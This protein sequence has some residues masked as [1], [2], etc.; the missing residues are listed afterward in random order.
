MSEAMSEPSLTPEMEQE[1][2]KYLAAEGGEAMYESDEWLAAQRAEI[3]ALRAERD[4]AN[5]AAAGLARVLV[6]REAQ[7]DAAITHALRVRLGTLLAP[8]PGAVSAEDLPE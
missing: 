1:I 5:N 8:R 7:R 3:A 2:D 6:E 4:K